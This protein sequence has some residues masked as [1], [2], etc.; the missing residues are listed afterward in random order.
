M[1]PMPLPTYRDID[2]IHQD[3]VRYVLSIRIDALETYAV[4]ALVYSQGFDVRDLS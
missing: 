2:G 4:A 3:L 1:T